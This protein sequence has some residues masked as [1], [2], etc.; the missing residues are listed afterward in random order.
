MKN[1]S[2]EFRIGNREWIKESW[3]Q[4]EEGADIPAE[5]IESLLKRVTVNAHNLLTAP[6][7]AGGSKP[8]THSLVIDGKRFEVKFLEWAD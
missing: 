8:M 7:G 4:A 5:Q 2:V 3:G 1:V 6:T